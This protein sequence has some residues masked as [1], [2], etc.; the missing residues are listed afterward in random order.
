M[1][2]QIGR[3]S[4]LGT[5]IDRASLEAAAAGRYE[6]SDF[7]ETPADLRRRY[8]DSE[9]PFT[10]AQGVRAM[11][12]FERRDVL[13]EPP[14]P[15]AHH[16]VLCRNVLIYFDRETQE[17]LFE[18]FHSALAPDGFLVLGKVET[19]LGASRQRFA[20]VDARESAS[21]DGR[22]DAQRA[23][24]PAIM[25]RVAV[26]VAA[27]ECGTL[28]TFGLGSCVAIV[29]YDP[30]AQVGGIATCCFPTKRCRAIQSRGNFRPPRSRCSLP[31]WSASVRSR[32]RV[33]ARLVGGA[34]MFAAILPSVGINMGERNVL[35]T[36]EALSVGPR[37]DRRGGRWQ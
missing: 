30:V 17:R 32:S 24:N 19:L 33:R 21:F 23:G 12:H 8:F 14:P 16:L 28:A 4:V 36:R 25:V 3:V 20:A 5:D 34:S 29:L 35:A 13:S 11:V 18:V 26:W 6:E 37:S 15:G 10:P 9:P 27:S 1:L 7:V 2:G 31:T 22:D